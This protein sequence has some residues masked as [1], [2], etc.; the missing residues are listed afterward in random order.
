[1]P[2]REFLI[3]DQELVQEHRNSLFVTLAPSIR[4]F[5]AMEEQLKNLEARLEEQNRRI[6]EQG[7]IHTQGLDEL[8]QLLK[9]L[10]GV[11]VRN[12]DSWRA[13]GHNENEDTIRPQ[14]M[15]P[16]LQCPSFDGTI[17]GFGLESVTDISVY[18]ILL[19]SLR[20]N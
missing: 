5:Q 9:D 8:K 20:L 16:K 6:E 18:A 15:V 11:P 17:L 19:E 12:G 10:R 7:K 14:G 1:M 4:K 3:F 13:S 2:R